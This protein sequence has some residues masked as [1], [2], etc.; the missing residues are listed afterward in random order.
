MINAQALLFNAAGRIR[1]TTAAPTAFNAA[2]GF[3]NGL[4]CVDLNGPTRW[5]NGMP[6][7][8]SGKLSVQIVG[9]LAGHSQG[10]LPINDAGAVA[11]DTSAAITYYNAGLPYTAIHRL[12]L[13]AAE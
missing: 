3:T 4:L 11:I 6:F 5:A 13:A 9:N 12:A 1:N 7:V 8:A 10:G 2:L